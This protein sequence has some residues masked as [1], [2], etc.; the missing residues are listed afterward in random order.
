M[1]KRIEEL[2][3]A[4]PYDHPIASPDCCRRSSGRPRCLGHRGRNPTVSDRIIA[5][6]RVQEEIVLVVIAAPDNHLLPCPYRSM[7]DSGSWRVGN[8]GRGPGV[9]NRFVSR[10]GV[11]VHRAIE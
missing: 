4:T 1:A 8:A 6:T 11:Y 5:A 9:R 2:P 10:S 7:G 3:K